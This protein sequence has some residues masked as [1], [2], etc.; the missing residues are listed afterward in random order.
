MAKQ[1]L[2]KA[3]RKARKQASYI[4][5]EYYKNFDALD[6]L[7]DFAKIKEVK[8]PNKIT[9]AS[10]KFIRKLYKEARKIAQQAAKETGEYIPTK[11]EMAKRVRNEPT[12]R[13]RTDRANM[14]T[15]EHKAQESDF[16]AYL[17]Y[18]Q[19]IRDA[20]DAL[21]PRDYDQKGK[22]STVRAFEEARLRL[23][24][25]LDFALSKTD[26]VILAKTLSES[27][28]LERIMSIDNQYAYQM[29]D[30]IDSDETNNLGLIQQLQAA[31][32]DALEQI[33]DM[34]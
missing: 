31:M 6:Y 13:Y 1:K 5:T 2:T 9:K 7:R 10:L 12:Q 23:Y 16:N 34:E 24:G 11:E 3:Q 29:I 32:D 25:M 4:R 27:E 30:D 8:I 22:E 19:M 18:I 28:Y 15:A 33:Y 20:I 26:E 14:E 21:M 17:G